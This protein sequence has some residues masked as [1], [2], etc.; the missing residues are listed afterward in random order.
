MSR[1]IV[2]SWVARSKR[3]GIDLAALMFRKDGTSRPVKLRNISY[4]GCL[5]HADGELAIGEKVTLA[6][7]RMGEMKAQIRWTSAAG[8][9]GARFVAEEILANEPHSRVGL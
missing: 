6:L 8:A 1:T 2:E 3:H 7:P 5:L 4:D 9:A